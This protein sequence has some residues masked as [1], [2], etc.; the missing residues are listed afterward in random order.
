M[1]DPPREEAKA[2]VARIHVNQAPSE[3]VLRDIRSSTADILEVTL[4]P[5]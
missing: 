4:L 3:E 5:I 1:I 2:A